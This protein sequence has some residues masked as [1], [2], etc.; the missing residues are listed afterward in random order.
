MDA[1]LAT[2]DT[3]SG[4]PTAAAH[5]TPDLNSDGTPSDRGERNGRDRIENTLG[6]RFN[7][8]GNGREAF[9]RLE[10]TLRQAGHGSQ[11]VI[12]TQDRHGRAHA[13][14][15]V[16]HQ[17]KITYVDSQTGRRS[18]QPL[19]SGDHGVHAVPLGRDRRPIPVTS[20]HS[21][22][23]SA[24]TSSGTPSRADRRAPAEPAGTERD[25]QRHPLHPESPQALHRGLPP[26]DAQ[27]RLRAHENTPV[28][29]ITHEVLDQHL[30]TWAKNGN[31]ADVLRIAAGDTGH[32]EGNKAGN[33]RTLTAKQLS[34]ALPGFNDL[35][36]GEQMAVV[37]TLGRLSHTYHQQYGVGSH[38][39][40]TPDDS[41]GGSLHERSGV[42]KVKA[43]LKNVLSPSANAEKHTPDLTGR[44]YAVIEVEGPNGIEYVVD[45]SYP[46]EPGEKGKHSE[47]NLADW[48]D[49]ANAAAG[50]D[51]YKIT[52]LYTEREPCG[53]KKGALG[54]SNC[55][56]FLLAL[57]RKRND[58]LPVYYSTEYRAD[59]ETNNARNK[60]RREL[61]AQARAELKTRKLNDETKAAINAEVDERIPDTATPEQERQMD[62]RVDLVRD[63]WIT[64][65][66]QV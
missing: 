10:N 36:R 15:A 51:K 56:D 3:Y 7:D 41:S 39:V 46:N 48:I 53:N 47:R 2:A 55:S 11:A 60:L 37:A 54:R 25:D 57:V 14:N 66:A 19:H 27:S 28:Y 38:P 50:G 64:I 32:P 17:G 31:L 22:V 24:D 45:S 63:L 9:N 5:R 16:N 1:A 30:R 26:D 58:K 61:Q 20:G 29:Q 52:S 44:N 49:K 13:W 62:E 21:T 18:D 12:I 40:N 6:A 33:P 43:L 59:L 8:Y 4:N 65:A 35:N 34:D 42:K 23:H